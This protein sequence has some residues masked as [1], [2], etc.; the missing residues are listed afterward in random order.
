MKVLVTGG[1]GLVGSECCRLFYD[2]G[3][4]VHS[5]DN[6]TRKNLFGSDGDTHT[7]MEKLQKEG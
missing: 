6:Y 2:N 5:V 7:N 4:E 1:A 3:W